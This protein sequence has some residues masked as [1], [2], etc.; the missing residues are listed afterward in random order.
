MSSRD[1]PQISQRKRPQQARSAALVGAILE[2]A[3][4]VL[5]DEG[6]TRFTTARVAERAGVSIGSL[7][8]FFPNKASLLFRLQ[9]EEWRETAAL[10]SGLLGDAAKPPGERL[11]N[12]AL[13]FVR[14]EFDEAQL[15]EAL[16]DAA[17]LYRHAP[18]AERARASAGHAV[19]NFMEEALPE[20]SA[21]T[22]AE[23]AALFETTL[24]A[25]G[26]RISQTCRSADAAEA[27]ARALA[28]MLC[29][30]LADLLRR[31]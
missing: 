7:Y 10:L 29:V 23:T 6:A 27:Q 4:Q 19:R 16:G 15:R 14:T 28:D 8:Q 20:A 3:A 5:R 13:A 31:T 2:A 11:R 22:R 18:E 21:A 1:N 30:Y 17:P 12:A 24:S 9:A 26:K 25:V